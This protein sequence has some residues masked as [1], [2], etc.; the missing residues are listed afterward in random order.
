MKTRVT[1]L[2]VLT[3]LTT[4]I[5]AVSFTLV[6]KIVLAQ[7]K[8]ALTATVRE[9]LYDQAGSVRRTRTFILAKRRDGSTVRARSWTKPGD[10]GVTEQRLI[11]DLSGAEEVFIDGLTESFTTILNVQEGCRGLQEVHKYG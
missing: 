7:D 3:S 11:L 8:T 6:Q 4:L 9:S 2:S 10:R 1:Y 5:A